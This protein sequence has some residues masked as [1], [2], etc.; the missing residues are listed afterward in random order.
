MNVL[1]M[2]CFKNLVGVTRMGRVSSDE[3]RGR[4]GMGREVGECSY[5]LDT[6]T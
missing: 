4:D 1:E 6:W 5:G 2:K 3:M